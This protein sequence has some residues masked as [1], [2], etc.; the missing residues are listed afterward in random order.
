MSNYVDIHFGEIFEIKSTFP[1]FNSIKIYKILQQRVAMVMPVY[2]LTSWAH[3]KT[4][5]PKKRITTY[6]KTK[7]FVSSFIPIYHFA[8]KNNKCMQWNW[9]RHLTTIERFSGMNSSV[10]VICICGASRINSNQFQW[11]IQFGWYDAFDFMTLQ[12][13]FPIRR[14]VRFD[15]SNASLCLCESVGFGFHERSTC[16]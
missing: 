9:S 3:S 11:L 12:T 14:S 1:S 8:R 4:K 5:Q 6:G 7:M 10:Y 13:I 2:S 16:F 15:W